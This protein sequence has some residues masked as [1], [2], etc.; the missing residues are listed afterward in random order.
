M[1]Y[2]NDQANLTFVKQYLSQLTLFEWRFQNIHFA[3]GK[4]GKYCHS[5]FL[6]T[7]SGGPWSEQSYC[8]FKGL[9]NLFPDYFPPVCCDWTCHSVCSR[10][11]DG[12]EMLSN[13]QAMD[14]NQ[15]QPQQ[16]YILGSRQ[17][18][19]I[20]DTIQLL[21]CRCGGNRGRVGQGC[22]AQGECSDERWEMG[23]QGTRDADR[24]QSLHRVTHQLT[25]TNKYLQLMINRSD[26]DWRQSCPCLIRV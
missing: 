3:N 13:L 4:V 20:K 18:D 5:G 12:K 21:S 1:H 15:S 2:F 9:V 16:W 24:K 11:T 7:Y 6:Q 8:C 14:R 22:G 17:K 10:V 23:R 25:V 19:P 26:R